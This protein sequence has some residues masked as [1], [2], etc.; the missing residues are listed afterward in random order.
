MKEYQIYLELEKT[1][2]QHFLYPIIFREYIY[3]L[4][5]GH[6]FNGSI[7]SKN[8]DYDNN[9]SLLIVKRLITLMDQHNHFII[10]ANDSKK[11]IFEL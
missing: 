2:Q 8:L 4:V 6:D 7:F 3:G 9:S 5:Y 1:H 10:S 11:S